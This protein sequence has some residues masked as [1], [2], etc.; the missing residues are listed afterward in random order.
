MKRKTA[1]LQVD[2]G[3]EI[4]YSKTTRE[5]EQDKLIPFE[6]C[7]RAQKLL[8]KLLLFWQYHLLLKTIATAFSIENKKKRPKFPISSFRSFQS[9]LRNNQTTYVTRLGLG[10]LS[11]CK[12]LS[13][14]CIQV[15]K[16][17]DC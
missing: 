14:F 1:N 16:S 4:Q 11:I 13:R 7:T 12:L 17:Q 2:M 9:N 10:R 6:I 3:N 5:R 8:G 15:V